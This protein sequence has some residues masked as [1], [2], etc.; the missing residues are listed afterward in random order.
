MKNVIDTMLDIMSEDDLLDILNDAVELK[1]GGQFIMKDLEITSRV[2]NHWAIK[3]LVPNISKVGD[4]RFEFSFLD[5]IW[6]N[7]VKELREYGYPLEKIK[8]V[9][10]ILL[11]PI[12]LNETLEN[13][14]NKKNKKKIM[15]HEDL[16]GDEFKGR[17]EVIKEIEKEIFSK[18]ENP[19]GFRLDFSIA[20]LTLIIGR[21]LL[22]RADV[23]ILI[24]N[25]GNV[26]SCP[27]KSIINENLSD[28]MV[29]DGFDSESYISIS[30]FK[31]LKNFIQKKENLEF[32]ISN[33]FLTENELQILSLVRDGKA[34]SITI[35]FDGQK[36][37][38]IEYTQE[39]KLYAESRISDVLIKRGY[40]DIIIKTQDG[41]I[42]FSNV[43]IKKKLK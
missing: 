27:K 10:D 36:P 12:L 11:E 40:Q 43:T 32:I 3:G 22:D 33:K 31:F 17:I 9:K 16:L 30:L 24:D 6:F 5:L 35:K 20:P 39:K 38:F 42:A 13:L 34:N 41:N 14:S 26:F 1:K 2:F 18:K 7:I 28:L 4:Y 15:N 21:F 19:D 37:K 8:I 29:E 25:E 23:R